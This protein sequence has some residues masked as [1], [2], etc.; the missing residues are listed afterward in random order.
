MTDAPEAVADLVVVAWDAASPRAPIRGGVV[1][2]PGPRAGVGISLFL[3]AVVADAG[4][5]LGPPWAGPCWP[6]VLGRLVSPRG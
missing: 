5:S 6:D 3:E 2:V 4:R 1:A